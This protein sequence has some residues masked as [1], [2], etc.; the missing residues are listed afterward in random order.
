MVDLAALPSAAASE[1]VRVRLAGPIP[2]WVAAATALAAAHGPARAADEPPQGI[3]RW[4]DPSTA[5]FI[6][7]PDIDHDPN[8]GTTLGLIPTRLV[9]DEQGQIRKIIAPDVNYNPYF[10]VGVSGSIYAFLSDDTQWSLVA[11]AKQRVESQFDYEYQSGIRRDTALS[12]DASVVYDRSGTP[13]FYGIGNNSPGYDV[14]NYTLQQKYVQTTVGWNLS[15]VWQTAYTLRVRDVAVQPGTLAGIESLQG[16]FGSIL[17]VGTTH[18][19]LSRIEIIYDTRDDTIIPTRG[20]QYVVFGG[21]A[22]QDGLLD[23]S[24]YSVTGVDARQLWS[25][26]PGNI[27]IAHMALRYMPGAT[28][29]PFWSL[30]NIGG[31]QSVLA[32][33]QPLRDCGEGR[34]LRAQFIFRAASNTANECS[35]SMRWAPI[36]TSKLTPFVDVGEV[37][38]HS[39]DSPVAHLHHVGG[40]GFRGIAS[41]FVVGYVDVGYGSEG[42]RRIHRNQL[43]FLK[44]DSQPMSH[45]FHRVGAF[46]GRHPRGV[47]AA[48]AIAIALGVW[49]AGEFERAA[50]NGT[51]GLYGSPSNEVAETLRSDF[52]V[53]FLE[54]LVVAFSEPEAVRSMTPRYWLGTAI[55]A[56]AL[57]GLASVKRVAAY[58]DSGDPHLRAPN[59]HQGLLLVELA[60]TDV[61]GQQRAVPL[62]R[63]ALGAAASAIDG[64]RST[65]AGRGDRRAGGRLRH[66]YLECA[67]RRSRGEAGLAAHARHPDPRLR[68]PDRRGCC[69]F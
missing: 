18:E 55:A 65:G 33:N 68:H 32:E 4:F 29:V 17:G 25:P 64:A 6:P 38:A 15:H 60:A 14:T 66:Q 7:I 11:G 21:V 58:S 16:R 46:V 45:V 54:P 34:F 42:A 3:A 9:T 44:P 51:S 56:R 2:V 24:L 10:G 43:P 63:A 1:S 48:W 59:G 69:R 39:R 52:V 41:P 5:P 27:I 31:E 67:R 23:S 57:R 61:P 36:S 12:F 20:G 49:G 50:Q 8:S 53:P 35:A 62:V 40:L 28:D 30:S 47:L 37:F 22:A 13:R 26:A 19:T